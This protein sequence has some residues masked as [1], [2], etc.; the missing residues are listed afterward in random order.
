MYIGFTM[1]CVPVKFKF[2]PW[3]SRKGSAAEIRLKNGTAGLTN[4]E[5]LPSYGDTC[6]R[7]YN[8]NTPNTTTPLPKNKKNMCT[9]LIIYL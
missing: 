1:I 6:I 4:W 3:F 9:R 7:V 8:P 2:P 5:P